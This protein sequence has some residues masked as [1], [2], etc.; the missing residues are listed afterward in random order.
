[1]GIDNLVRMCVDEASTPQR[2]PVD[3]VADVAGQLGGE[4]AIQHHD[5]R[6]LWTLTV[7]GSHSSKGCSEIIY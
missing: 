6:R 2:I 4:P 1:M 7:R 5:L 3:D